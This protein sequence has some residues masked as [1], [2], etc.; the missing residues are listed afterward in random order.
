M[1]IPPFKSATDSPAEDGEEVDHI[2][3]IAE[4]VCSV[5]PSDKHDFGKEI[6][7]DM[8]I[9]RSHSHFKWTAALR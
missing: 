2:T 3:I 8:L 7:S 6:Y 5:G 9:V 1:Q 4:N